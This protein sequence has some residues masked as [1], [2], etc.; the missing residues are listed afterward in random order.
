MR[1]MNLAASI[2]S[3]SLVARWSI[4]F[5][6][7]DIRQSWHLPIIRDCRVYVRLCRSRLSEA[8]W[9]SGVEWSKN[10]NVVVV[11]SLRHSSFAS[12]SAT[13]HCA[14]KG[15]LHE[16]IQATSRHRPPATRLPVNVNYL[17]RR[18]VLQ[19]TQRRS[20][21]CF[22]ARGRSRGSPSDPWHLERLQSR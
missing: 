2:A 16:R 15:R 17:L 14:E 12:V 20:V 6:V 13:D 1:S 21:D 5:L 3:A 9:N 18:T 19:A 10:R 7:A 11:E 22:F 4:L 8:L